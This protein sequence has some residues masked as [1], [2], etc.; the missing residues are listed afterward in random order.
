MRSGSIDE[1]SPRVLIVEDEYFIADDVAR[2]FSAAGAHIVAFAPSVERARAIIA[3]PTDIDVAILDVRLQD[4]EVF[5][6]ADELLAKGICLV[7]FTAT[8]SSQMPA[9]FADI[10]VVLKP[11]GAEQVYLEAC[12]ACGAAFSEAKKQ[13]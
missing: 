5:M 4:G 10:P 7:F 9:R 11:A 6:L 13:R 3:R 1:F 2:E 12:R 8:E